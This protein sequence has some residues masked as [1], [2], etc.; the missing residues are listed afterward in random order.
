VTDEACGEFGYRSRNEH[1][2]IENQGSGS[3]ESEKRASVSHWF[4]SHSGT[5]HCLSQCKNW[6]IR[7]VNGGGIRGIRCSRNEGDLVKRHRADTEIS[8]G[9]DNIAANGGCVNVCCRKSNRFSTKCL[10]EMKS[11]L[12]L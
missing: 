6:R 12:M 1:F 4:A 3:G 9:L 7:G 5:I 10:L 8:I 2:V 11:H